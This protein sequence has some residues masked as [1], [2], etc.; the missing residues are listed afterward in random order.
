MSVK[1]DQVRS[2]S[3]FRNMVENGPWGVGGAGRVGPPTPT[4]FGGLAK[5]L[6]T[7]PET[8]AELVAAD[9]YGV[10]ANSAYSARVKRMAPTIESLSDSDANMIEMLVSRL[11]SV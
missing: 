3:W 2:H 8:V 11:G 7:T 9:F 1:A 4:E 6:G 10:D 5:L